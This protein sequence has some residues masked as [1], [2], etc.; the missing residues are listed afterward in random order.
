MRNPQTDFGLA[1][2]ALK[3][4]DDN[5]GVVLDWLKDNGLAQNTIV[6]F[7]TDNGAEV[8]TW[9]DGGNTP[10]AGAKGEVTEG[11]FRVPA[12]IRWPG[13]VPS[14]KVSCGI[15]SGPDW[16]PTLVAAA[17]SPAIIDQLLKGQQLGDKTYKVHLDGYDQTD[18]I[19]GKG[20]K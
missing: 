15:M 10:F 11:S 6:V 13:K 20:P 14:G 18:L 12:I 16:F 9:R 3:R 19:I 4:M 7:T 2:A 5:V 8:Y 1:E 17:G